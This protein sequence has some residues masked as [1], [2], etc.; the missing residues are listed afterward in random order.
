MDAIGGFVRSGLLSSRFSDRENRSSF[1]SDEGP[2]K[3]CIFQG[4]EVKYG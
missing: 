3:L 4:L 2:S 1:S